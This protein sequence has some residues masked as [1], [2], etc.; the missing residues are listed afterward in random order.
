MFR[1][2]VLVGLVVVAVGC[3]REIKWEAQ[4]IKTFTVGP[5][6]APIPAGWRDLHELVDKSKIPQLEASML[7]VETAETEVGFQ[8]NIIGMWGTPE[9]LLGAAAA[10]CDE[11]AKLVIE[12][13]KATSLGKAVEA[14]VEGDRLCTFSNQINDATG[15]YRTR[16][17]GDQ[18][19]FVQCL[20]ATKGD[21]IGDAGCAAV[22]GALELAQ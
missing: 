6:T 12:Q 15:T 4:K 22:W 14:T 20:R 10:T 9:H 18:L 11:V 2:V 21:P 3:K 7:T 13:Q 8:A 5:F 17:H 1:P 16:F 19:L